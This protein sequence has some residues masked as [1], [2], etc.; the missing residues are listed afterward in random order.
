MPSAHITFLRRMAHT[1]SVLLRPALLSGIPA[2]GLAIALSSA[3]GIADQA[4]RGTGICLPPLSLSGPAV[5]SPCQSSCKLSWG[6]STRN[7]SRRSARVSDIPCVVGSNPFL[8][9]RS[10]LCH[11]TGYGHGFLEDI[12]FS[13]YPVFDGYSAVSGN[14]GASGEWACARLHGR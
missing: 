5:R 2:C 7:H 10:W 12:P 11:W 9:A 13:S 4:Y 14:I 8:V 3:V 6:P 1:S